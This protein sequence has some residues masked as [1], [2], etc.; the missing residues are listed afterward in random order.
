MRDIYVL[1]TMINTLQK[2]IL[3]KSGSASI[4]MTNIQ[5]L[6][7]EMFCVSRNIHCVKHVRI[8]SYSG[9][10][11]SR[12]FPGQNNS[13]YGHFLRSDIVSHHKLYFQIKGQQSV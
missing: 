3:E 4:H 11:F 13:E 10:H 12:I 6:A 5:S 1:L 7:V 2:S 8:R 9:P